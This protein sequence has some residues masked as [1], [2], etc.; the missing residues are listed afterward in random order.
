MSPAEAAW[1]AVTEPLVGLWKA[2]ESRFGLLA[3]LV[4]SDPSA[5]ER[6]QNVARL[7]RPVEPFDQPDFLA[8]LIGIAGLLAGALL[9]G[10][11]LVSLG[12][13]LLSL[14]ALGL[15][16]TRVFGISVEVAAPGV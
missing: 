3:D 14:I 4:R 2:L 15:L 7:G 1:Q 6:W 12:S 8:P 16:L 9:C 5:A 13:L 11:A 10:V